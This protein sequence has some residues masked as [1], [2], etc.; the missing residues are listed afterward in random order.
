MWG[1]VRGNATHPHFLLD[2][3]HDFL[4][5]RGSRAAAAAGVLQRALRC[6][7]TCRLSAAEQ[8]DLLSRCSLQ[9]RPAETSVTLLRAKRQIN[10]G[11]LW[12]PP[13]WRAQQRRKR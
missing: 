1:I 9:I 4:Q 10:V 7:L 12:K 5:Q 8:P 11:D 3:V 2:V 6:L 13:N